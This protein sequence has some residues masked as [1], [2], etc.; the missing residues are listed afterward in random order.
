ML[1][2]LD[3][4]IAEAG[5]HGLKMT[6]ALL[7]N[8]Q[9]T[10]GIPEYL[11]FCSPGGKHMDFYSWSSCKDL[12]KNNAARIIGRVNTLT[13]VAYR[14]DPT[15]MSWSLLNEPRCTGPERK[16]GSASP[17]CADQLQA[18]AHFFIFFLIIIIASGRGLGLEKGRVCARARVGAGPD[19]DL[20]HP[21]PPLPSPPPSFA[22]RYRKGV[23]G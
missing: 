19:A 4:A 15:I 22:M 20:N 7:D 2:G 9:T 1:K 14:D 10:G 21:H 8:W 3:F 6:L 16:P 18:R 5:K 11:D 17:F 12:Y 23:A 13:G